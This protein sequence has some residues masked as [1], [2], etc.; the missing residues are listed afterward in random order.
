MF[1]DCLKIYYAGGLVAYFSHT[2]TLT[3]LYA[4]GT[5][6]TPGINKGALFGNAAV[7]SNSFWSPIASAQATSGA[8]SGATSKTVSE[9]QTEST[10]STASWD[11]STVPVWKMPA[12]V[13]YPIL[14][15][16]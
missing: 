11:F 10:F 7:A 2:W 12:S 13:G 5:V 8:T 16:Q 6:I 1:Q 14:N 9:L 4:A 3:R 15:W